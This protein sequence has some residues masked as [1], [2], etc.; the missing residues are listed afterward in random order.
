[1]GVHVVQSGTRVVG[2]ATDDVAH[3]VRVAAEDTSRVVGRAGGP[4]R[5]V[6]LQVYAHLPCRVQRSTAVLRSDT[7]SAMQAAKQDALWSTPTRWLPLSA[8]QIPCWRVTKRARTWLIH[9]R[10]MTICRSSQKI[11]ICKYMLYVQY[12]Y[13]NSS[14]VT[15]PLSLAAKRAT[16]TK[17]L[18]LACGTSATTWFT[19][20]RLLVALVAIPNLHRAH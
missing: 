11:I 4:Y 7:L 16:P 15:V 14:A 17:L 8:T 5:T 3:A 19:F 13:H 18:I 10:A 2:R 12:Y 20:Q 6:A 1:M 9:K